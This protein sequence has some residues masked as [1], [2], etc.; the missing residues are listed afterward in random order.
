MDD[1]DKLSPYT[2]FNSPVCKKV[3][4]D[5]QVVNRYLIRNLY[6]LDVLII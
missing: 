1:T 6:L 4:S 2:L 5:R 3:P